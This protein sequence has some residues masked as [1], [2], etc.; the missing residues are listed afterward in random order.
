MGKRLEGGAGE[1]RR[2]GR[3]RETG[4]ESD[5]THLPS[6]YL[7]SVHCLHFFSKHVSKRAPLS[8]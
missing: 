7:A 2:G 3:R 6:T 4:E 8:F 5:R 1:G